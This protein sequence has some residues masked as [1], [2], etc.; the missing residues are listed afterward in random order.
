MALGWI[1]LITNQPAVSFSDEDD[2]EEEE[3]S[4]ESRLLSIDRIELIQFAFNYTSKL[5]RKPFPWT[6]DQINLVVDVD[7]YGSS[8]TRAY[9][10]VLQLIQEDKDA[11]DKLIADALMQQEELNQHLIP[12]LNQLVASFV[13]SSIEP[14]KDGW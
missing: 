3:E 9:Q 11:Q 7:M 5:Y 13:S 6:S 8:T 4:V 10:L 1:I 14:R 12:D 2:E